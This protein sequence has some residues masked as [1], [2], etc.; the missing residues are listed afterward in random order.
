M[1]SPEVLFERLAPRLRGILGE[2]LSTSATDLDLHGRDESWHA[3]VAPQGVAYVRSKEE[4]VAVVRCCAEVG[5]P[6][7]PFGAGSSLEGHVLPFQGGLSLDLSQMNRV[8]AVRPDDLD[9]TVEA[10][11]TRRQ[12][13]RRLADQ[14]LFFAVDPGADATFG[15]MAAT[16]ASGTNAVRYGTMREN[17]VNLEVV[18]ADGEIITTGRRVR[19]SSTGYDLTHLFVGS[20]GTLGVITEATVRLFGLPE[21][22]VAAVVG[23]E[24]LEQAVRT[25]MEIIQSGI[26]VARIELLD[27][28]MVDAV[29]RYAGSGHTVQPT[30]FLEFHGS[31]A[32]VQEQTADVADIAANHGGSALRWAT[33]GD[34]RRELWHARHH[35]YYA[36]LALRPGSRGWSTD[37]C[38][39][40]SCLA[41]CIEATRQDLE[42]SF[43]EAPLVGHVGDGNFHLIIVFDPQQAEER[44]EAQ[45]L[46]RRLV[47]RALEFGGTCSGEH[48]V[49][50][51]KLEFLQEEHG[52][53]LS[54]RRRL[55]EALD[56]KGLFNPGK[57]I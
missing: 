50:V 13:N 27:S 23:F 49:G 30:L 44:D 53:A 1:S 18:L 35:A 10:G 52:A 51:G 3:P 16:R 38:V 31:A 6:I 28:T 54:V 12:L 22:I 40:I 43:L 46:N 17:V 5:L 48:G 21:S 36:A 29:N 20:E 19:K 9:A 2:R 14:G 57:L 4:V 47:R 25:A 33:D 26:P 34:E 15:G 42:S 55:K 8:L 45:R 37:V 7:I 39:P 11:V 32:G 56:P 41:D 24:S